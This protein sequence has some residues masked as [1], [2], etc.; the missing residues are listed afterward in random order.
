MIGE[1][2]LAKTRL[3]IWFNDAKYNADLR[4]PI[5]LYVNIRAILGYILWNDQVTSS[6][7]YLR[8]I[9]ATDQWPIQTCI[10]IIII[11]AT[12]AIISII[13][14]LFYKSPPI[15][16]AETLLHIPLAW[17][18]LPCPFSL[19]TVQIMSCR[20]FSPHI[21]LSLLNARTIYPHKF[22]ISACRPIQSP[23]AMMSTISSYIVMT[24]PHSPMYNFTLSFLSFN[25]T[26]HI[27]FPVI[28]GFSLSREDDPFI[29]CPCFR[30]SVRPIC[31]VMSRRF[32]WTQARSV[33]NICI[34]L[35]MLLIF[36]HNLLNV[37]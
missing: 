21:F 23:T 15:F 2:K 27:H 29:A 9:E 1:H 6:H 5:V 32:A 28:Y 22:N 7:K 4:R 8:R 31:V 37:T 19:P 17:Q 12:I 20:T 24:R 33:R 11:T 34:I 16:H 30:L 35:I 18:G 26:P 3:C 13:H 10:I 25:D 36:E 14:H